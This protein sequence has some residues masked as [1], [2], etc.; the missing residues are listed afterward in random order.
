M[1]HFFPHCLPL[2]NSLFHCGF[3]YI[4]ILSVGQTV[5]AVTV[6]TRQWYCLLE[7][8]R[9][10]IRGG[11]KDNWDNFAVLVIAAET[12]YPCDERPPVSC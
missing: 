5:P 9:N 10:N 8:E 11:K 12:N 7:L 3:L 2:L 1:H 4:P 6:C